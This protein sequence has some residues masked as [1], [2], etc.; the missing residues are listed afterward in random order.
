MSN[1]EINHEL[2]ALEEAQ[3]GIFLAL[4][5]AAGRATLQRACNL[6]ADLSQDDAVSPR[7]RGMFERFIVGAYANLEA[8]AERP[9]LEV[10]TGGA[11]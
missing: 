9:H 7:T 2:Q 5:G 3:V 10:I 4:G 11:A 8:D 1:T 6:L